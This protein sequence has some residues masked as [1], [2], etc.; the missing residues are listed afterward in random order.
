M[1]D[2]V[3][4]EART[5]VLRLWYE[6]SRAPEDREWRGEARDVLS[7]R[8]VYFRTLDRLG[9]AVADLLGEVGGV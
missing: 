3:R 7:D 5:V 6:E 9:A 4:R 8:V 1:R 2:P